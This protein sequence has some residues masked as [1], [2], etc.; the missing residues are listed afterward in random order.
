M[1]ADVCSELELFLLLCGSNSGFPPPLSWKKEEQGLM[2]VL[3]LSAMQSCSIHH[4]VLLLLTLTFTTA[5][6]SAAVCSTTVKLHQPVTLSCEHKCSGSV[7]WTL[8]HN[9]DEI[10]AQCN[11]T[12]CS[13]REGFS[14]SHDQYLKGDL[15]LSITAADYSLRNTYSCECGISEISTVRLSIETVFSAVQKKLGEDLTLNVSVPEPVEVVYKGSDSADGE[16]ICT[17]T[18][19]S[20]QCP[21]EYTHRTSLSFPE[22]TLRDVRL[23]DSG[24]YTV[25]DKENNEDIQIYAVSVEDEQSGFPA[26]GIIVIIVTVLL[27]LLVLTGVFLYLK[28]SPHREFIKLS[29]QLQHVD[30]RVKQAQPRQDQS[31]RKFDMIGTALTKVERELDQLE[32][33][34]RKNTK[35]SEQVSLF[36]RAKREELDGYRQQHNTEEGGRLLP[37]TGGSNRQLQNVEERNEEGGLPLTERGG[38]AR[39]GRRQ[40]AS[41]YC[42]FIGE[43]TP[44]AL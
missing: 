11:Q 13:S 33:Q 27:V 16:V 23:S 41:L 44:L 14:I 26:W 3:C 9:R 25:R 22:L 21:A 29:R 31:D 30:K 34:Y 35:Y 20:L 18:Q 15:S 40:E 37:A 17:V 24:R 2:V 38:K 36:C 8:Y 42:R 39:G 32:E 43:H 12:S 4:W 6:V 10:F 1:C 28:S 7:K 19:R 5:P